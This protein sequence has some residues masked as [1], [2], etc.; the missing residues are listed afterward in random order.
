M[1]LL[2]VEILYY[3]R[4]PILPLL[5]AVGMADAAEDAADLLH[6]SPPSRGDATS[7]ASDTSL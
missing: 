2:S 6:A 4:P 3:L 1:N 5:D 7:A